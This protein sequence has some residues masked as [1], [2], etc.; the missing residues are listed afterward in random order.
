M[1]IKKSLLAATA[2]AIPALIVALMTSGSV[3]AGNTSPVLV[4]NAGAAQAVPVQVEGT[5]TIAGSVS[6]GNIPSVIVS[7]T[8]SV[9]LANSP[10]VSSQQAGAWNVGIN[11]TPTV[12][13]SA[14]ANAVQAQQSGIWNVGI[15][16][17]PTVSLS[18][19]STVKVS[20]TTV[21]A[22]NTSQYVSAGEA[23]LF[24][25]FDVSSYKQIR[26]GISSGGSFVANISTETA[27]SD[28]AYRLDSTNGT[29]YRASTE[30][31]KV[32]DTPGELLKV[33]VFNTSLQPQV[34]HLTIWARTN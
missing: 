21:N 17:T 13:L 23:G 27:D 5:A 16:G 10:T 30:Y 12:G 19:L 29:P 7:N 9:T 18:G 20:G 15:T 26:V 24:G 11:G 6:I 4:T 33:D 31:L 8:P 14:S 1:R 25:L 34:I 28:A 32:F 22:F 3:Q 2:V